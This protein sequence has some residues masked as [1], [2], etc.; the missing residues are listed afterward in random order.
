MTSTPPQTVQLVNTT[1]AVLSN[2]RSLPTRTK[3]EDVLRRL[4][5]TEMFGTFSEVEIENCLKRVLQNVAV[6][7]PPAKILVNRD[8]QPWLAAK[9]MRIDNY[10]WGRYRDLLMHKGIPASV[11]VELETS[12][13]AVLDKTFDPDDPNSVD[14]RGLVM[15]NV[16]SGKTQH[17]L[18]LITKAADAGYKVIIVIAGLHNSL[19]NQT[20]ERVDEGFVGVRWNGNKGSRREPVGVG[21]Y[22]SGVQNRMPN[23]FTASIKDFN[24]ATA[25]SVNV[26]LK[27]LNEPAIFV[28]KK[29]K[30]TL[31][32]LISWLE[33][34]K[35]STGKIAESLLLIDD[36]ADNASINT[37]G[38]GADPSV[39]NSLIRSV[40]NSFAKSAY[41]AYTATPFANI[42]IDPETEDEMFEDDLFPQSF[43]IGLEPP[44]NYMGPTKVFG[45]ESSKYLCELDDYEDILP[46]RHKS[47]HRLDSIPP[48]MRR[49]ICT[50]LISRSIRTLRGQGSEH[51]AMMINASRFILI[52][53]QLFTQVHLV[54][55]ELKNAIQGYASLP[56]AEAME[57]QLIVELYEAFES[58]YL[59]CGH[60]WIDVLE[61]LWTAVAPI[62]IMQVNM[63]SSS[64]FD[65]QKYEGMG[66]HVIAIGGLSLSR[67]LTL[68]GLTVSYYLRNTQMYDTLLQMGRWFGYR[69]GFEDL[70]RIWMPESSQDWYGHVTEVIE[71]LRLELSTMHAQNMTPLEFGLKVR[72]HPGSLMITARNKHGKHHKVTLNMSFN[73]RQVETYK[74][75]DRVRDKNISALRNFESQVLQ[76]GLNVNDLTKKGQSWLLI[77][78]VP[79]DA[80]VSFLEEYDVDLDAKAPWIQSGPMIEYI[81]R[82]RNHLL[83]WDVAIPSLRNSGLKKDFDLFGYTVNCQ[84]RSIH[85]LR[86]VTN[87]QRFDFSNRRRLSSPGIDRAGMS[88]M[89]IF[90][91]EQKWKDSDEGNSSRSI[92][93]I[94]YRN[95]RTTPLLSLHLVKPDIK[96][97]ELK[98]PELLGDKMIRESLEQ[99]FIGWG[100]SFPDLGAND[101][102]IP[103]EYSVTK[104]WLQ[105]QFDWEE[106]E[107]DDDVE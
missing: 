2:E 54:V 98:H 107:E 96:S 48:S 60:E 32:T 20:Q 65:Y 74:M 23:A 6:V 95:E 57:N 67:G 41:V 29:N 3:V 78:N 70:V 49:A 89:E 92:P 73:L 45:E 90:R 80:V 87:G 102:A 105:N 66:R 34:N 85:D 35:D 51:S 36:E 37:N 39:I 13:E 22:V 4:A 33:T 43:I 11:L 84:E 59:D 75:S 17:Y 64:S 88:E 63:Q 77:K 21:R 52:Q 53:Q 103:I 18:G 50:Y 62:E 10:F 69:P 9:K 7:V 94:A 12:V 25:Q 26:P 83:L 40:L 24:I 100:V 91:A 28:I 97:S 16:Q 30:K 61:K 58:S 38:E 106:E 31:E 71:E 81:K 101:H 42:F 1:I 5:Q 104:A 86:Q 68:E 47:N 55:T 19:R 99:V 8:H 56:V 27:N 79:L 93:D 72:C 82:H 76:L 44:S 14:R 46:L 15:G